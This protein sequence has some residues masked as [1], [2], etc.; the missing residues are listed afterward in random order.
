MA[1]S[2]PRTGFFEPFGGTSALFCG[3]CRRPRSTRLWAVHS[4]PTRMPSSKVQNLA[5]MR[6]DGGTRQV[7]ERTGTAVTHRKKS[8]KDPDEIICSA[9]S[10]VVPRR[11]P[12]QQQRQAKRHSSYKTLNLSRPAAGQTL[13]CLIGNEQHPNRLNLTRPPER[14]SGGGE[15]SRLQDK[16]N[17]IQLA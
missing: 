13:T 2:E 3:A 16:E 15:L 1:R 10:D 17:H 12:L 8:T 11:H 5:P 14:T 6:E 7:A 9:H 4:I